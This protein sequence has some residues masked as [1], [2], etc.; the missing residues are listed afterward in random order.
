MFCTLIGAIKAFHRVHYDWLLKA[1][2]MR[3]RRHVLIRLLF[4]LCSNHRTMIS[5]VLSSLFQAVNG[6]KQ[7]SILSPVFIFAARQSDSF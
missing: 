2:L 3:D 1:L 5:W 6:V 4:N 7:G